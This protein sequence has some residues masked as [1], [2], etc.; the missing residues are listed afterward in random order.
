MTAHN[1]MMSTIGRY[2]GCMSSLLYLGGVG[3]IVK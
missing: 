3:I 2:S 1:Q